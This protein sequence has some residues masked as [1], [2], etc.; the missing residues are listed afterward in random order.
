MLKHYRHS[1]LG[2]IVATTLL[3]NSHGVA[4]NEYWVAK[5]GQD[6]NSCTNENDDACLTIQRGVSLL[7]AGDTLNVKAGTYRD[8]GGKSEFAPANTTCG[9]L[10]ANPP[11]SNV[12]V[13]VNG[14]ALSPI[15]IQAAPG[16]EGKVVID[17]QNNKIGI[18]LQNSDYIHVRGFK[19]INS[20]TIGIASWGQPENAVADEGRLSIGCVIEGNEISDTNGDYGM[21]VSGIGPWGTKDWVIRNNYIHDIYQDGGRPASAI[22]SYGVINALV[23]N[24]YMVNVGY[25]IFWKDHFVRDEQTRA[26]NFESEI[27]FNQIHSTDRGINISIRGTNSPEAGENFI[28]NNIIYGFGNSAGGIHVALSG[29][30]G[31][32]APIRI[33]NNLIDGDGNASRGISVDSSRDVQI[34]GNLIIRTKPQM[35]FIVYSSGDKVPRIFAS[36]RNIFDSTFQVI[37]DRYSDSGSKSFASLGSWQA[38]TADQIVSLQ[39][40]NPDTN[41]VMASYRDIFVDIGTRNYQYKAGSPA[42]GM[43][44]NGSNAGPFQYGNEIV[45]LLPGWPASDVRVIPLPPSELR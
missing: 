30:Y 4:A 32:S 8:D 45:G 3:V 13:N 36:D 15:V 19:V 44:A 31:I 7:R 23:E 42:I 2:F 28:H 17:A 38:S 39:V 9:W 37:A 29:A 22:Q 20:R 12:C 11:S 24:N 40:N 5:T 27:R 18:H 1:V 34:R 26:P 16:D 35:E 6:S 10:D 25:G 43:M 21:N 41:S 33:E 14:T